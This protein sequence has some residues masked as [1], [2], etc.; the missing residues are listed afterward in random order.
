MLTVKP[1]WKKW[2]LLNDHGRHI[3]AFKP[4]SDQIDQHLHNAETVSDEEIVQFAED[5]RFDSSINPNSADQVYRHCAINN[6]FQPF[7]GLLPQA[8]SAEDQAVIDS[9]VKGINYFSYLQCE[10]GHWPGDYGGPLF[11]LPGLLIASYISGT[12]F[13]KAHREMMKLYIFNHQ[14]PDAGWGM[15]I[16]GESTM[17]GTVMQYVSL[18]IL[19]V[20]KEHPTIVKAR[21]WIKNNGGAAGVPSWGKFYLAVM[22]L[23]DWR[24]FNSLFPEMWLLPKWL[25]MHPSRYWCHCRMVYLPM[26]YCQA[27]RIQ[28]PED[29][30]V[31][32]LREE[33][34]ENFDSIDWP[35]QRDAVCDKDRY[36]KPSGVLKWMN[37][38]TNTYEKFAS[39]RLRKKTTNYILKYLDAEDQQTQYIDI[40][41]VSKAINSIC[42]WHAYGKDSDRFKRHVERWYD[43]LW[44]AEDGMKMNGYNGSQLWDTAL[45]TRAI[46]ESDLGKRF[47]KTI[48][49]SY[50]FIERS[51]IK[52][53]HSTHAEFFRHPM[54][55]SWPF[56]TAD[57]GWPVSDCTAEG[58]SAALS[59]HRS[60][61]VEAVID[62]Q[63]MKQAIDI[64]LSYQNTNGGWSTYELTRAP[65]WL[66][67]LN[68]SEV[69]ADIMI[70]YSWT[71]CSAACLISLIE[72]QEDYPAY[73][74]D[75]ISKAISAGLGFIIKQQKADGSW[76]GGWAVCFTY[77]TWFAVETLSKALNKGYFD[78]T[79]LADSINKACAFLVGKQKADGGWGESFKSCSDLVY[80]E[81]ATSQS[82][83]TAWA[84]LALLS[85]NFQDK[86]VIDKG[87]RVLLNK[88]T[89]LGDWHQENIS[90]VFNYNC[91]ITYANYRN[92]FP[93]WALNRYCRIYNLRMLEK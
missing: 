36:Y 51:Q 42:I 46:L 64:I 80:T 68:P 56:S 63:R 72:S 3:W 67:K 73:K 58:L 34:Y 31:L 41:P 21:N 16:E 14:N 49:R 35:K 8:K 50:R 17:F 30:L 20:D 62:E 53:E 88:Q 66:E 60:G 26:A 29:E 39:S 15:H 54:I 61:L 55:G 40:G 79:V 18:R 33:L 19:G 74:N 6:Q 71:E 92:I 25:P 23:Y 2:R 83:N 4:V 65:R 52:S 7:D 47:P 75:E 12:P 69:F 90:G 86:S 43:Y 87:I 1:A 57:N 91:M 85:G 93:I 22:N 5:F 48:E 77:A 70:D 27:H 78:D 81:A 9:L 13:P 38:F 45:A 44:V 76:Y 59:I 11:L 32:S 24:G 28:A 37:L 89:E 84:L 82:V 10:D